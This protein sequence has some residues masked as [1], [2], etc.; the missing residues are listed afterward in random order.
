[1]LAV[2][3]ATGEFE[4]VGIFH[5]N[6]VSGNALNV[7]VAIDQIRDM[8]TTLK[9][10][11]KQTDVARAD[12][13]ARKRRTSRNRCMWRPSHRAKCPSSS[14]R[15]APSRRSRTSRSRRS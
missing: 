1:V 8:M 7:A 4:L 3:C 13:A 6:F 5:A 12:G 10:T 9:R 11:P 14:I 2:S 15:S